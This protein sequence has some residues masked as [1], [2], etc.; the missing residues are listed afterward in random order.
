MKSSPWPVLCFLFLTSQ[1]PVAQA[2]SR[3]MGP[4]ETL[5]L[6]EDLVLGRDDSLEAA[7]TEEKPCKIV[8][9]GHQVRTVENW[10]GRMALAHCRLQGLGTSALKPEFHAIEV[11]AKGSAAVTIEHCIFDECAS[12]SINNGDKSTAAFLHNTILANSRAP[13][14]KDIGDSR[15]SFHARGN[16]PEPKRFQ[17]NRIYKASAEFE[18]PNWLI[19]GDTDRESNHLVGH[20]VKI[21]ARGN[22]SVIRGNYLHVLMPRN[23]EFPYWSQVS[24]VDPGGNLLEH[25]VIRD[26]EWIVQMF[27]GEVRYNVICDINDHNLMRNGSAG[28][29]HHNIFHVG[30]PDHPPGSMSACIYIVYPPKKSG[31][32]MEIYNNTFD[33]CG[34]FEPPAVEVCKNGFVKS[35]RNNVFCNFNLSPYFKLPPAAIRASWNE[36]EL[37]M[38]ERL[39][40]ADYNAF[41]NPAAKAPRHYGLTV[42]GKTL[43]K[44]DGFAAHDLPAA[45]PADAQVDPRFAGPLFKEFPFRDDDIVADKVT[46]S[47]MLA[48]FR[49]AYMPRDDS[50]LIDAGDPADGRG[51]D[52]GAV[53]GGRPDEN[54]RFGNFGEKTAP[55]SEK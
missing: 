17:G 11:Q 18:S 49:K 19:G 10:Q 36:T 8:G 14:S 24:T 41:H 52:I 15:P 34:I 53:G 3:R 4:G 44:D 6:S 16:S 37:A 40:Y 2:E 47:Q 35:L 43:R 54:D 9:N 48:Y 25:N 1:W 46:V 45:G 30:R 29:V 31:E 21:L 33:G 23:K 28:K 13:V 51:T 22:T 42:M 12:V 38:P 7:G 20:R 55:A 50:P 26:G 32:G 5:T 39:G 27:E